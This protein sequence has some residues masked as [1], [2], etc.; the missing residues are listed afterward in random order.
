MSAVDRMPTNRRRH[1][2]RSHP[3]LEARLGREIFPAADW[4]LGGIGL[5][6]LA[7]CLD[8]RSAGSEIT[9]YFGVSGEDIAF[10]FSAAIARIDTIHDRVGL[11]FTRLWPESAEILDDL[12][13]R[14][15]SLRRPAAL[16]G[17]RAVL[18]KAFDATTARL[19]RRWQSP[20]P[21]G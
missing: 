1:I 4:S 19:A 18:L 9:G 17:P 10:K 15:P 13:R 7:D 2:R 11:D 14:P 3:N 12:F 16:L 21:R 6:G 20:P 5:R 8:R